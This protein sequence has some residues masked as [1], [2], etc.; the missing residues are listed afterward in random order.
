[1]RSEFTI[2]HGRDLDEGRDPHGLSNRFCDAGRDGCVLGLR[3]IN[4]ME[5]VGL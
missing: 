4:A 3:R 2:R 5:L 1:M